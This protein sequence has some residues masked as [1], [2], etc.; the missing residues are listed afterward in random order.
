V[1]SLLAANSQHCLQA[2]VLRIIKAAVEIGC[3][4]PLAQRRIAFQRRAGRADAHHLPP[5]GPG[6]QRLELAHRFLHAQVLAH[7]QFGRMLRDQRG[8]GDAPRTVAAVIAETA[9]I[10]QEI[11]IQVVV[12]T[13][14]DAAQRAITLPRR[15][16][17][18]CPRSQCIPK[19]LSADPICGCNAR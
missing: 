6:D 17:A 19:A 12:I 4:Y 2:M 7:A 10:T 3:P 13:I 16:V 5:A 14:D 8:P 18:P 15:G 1:Q 11:A 9:A